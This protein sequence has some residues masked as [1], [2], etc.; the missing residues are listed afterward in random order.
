[1]ANKETTVWG[2]HAG[3]TGDADTLF[4]KKN[5]VALGWSNAGDLSLLRDREAF[6]ARIAAAYPD[7]KP[8]SVPVNAGMLFRFIHEMKVGDNILYSS[9]HDKQVHIGRVDGDYRYDSS[10]DNSYPN[11]RAVV[12]LKALPTTRFSQGALYEIRTGMSFFLIKNYADECLS[13][14]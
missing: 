2:I 4:L 13:L 1:M 6:K 11:R 7:D 5:V 9:Q 14:L 8:G 12:W 10:G 3:R